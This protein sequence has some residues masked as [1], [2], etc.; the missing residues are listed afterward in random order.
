MKI[1]FDDVVKREM[2]NEISIN[3]RNGLPNAS[4]IS[5]FVYSEVLGAMG[6]MINGEGEN[7]VFGTG[8]SN[9]NFQSYLDY[10]GKVYS[11]VNAKEAYRVIRGGII[12]RY[13]IGRSAL[14]VINPEDPF[15]TVDYRIGCP[16]KITE[17]SVYFNVNQYFR[18]MKVTVNKIRR[19]MKR[20]R[21]ESLEIARSFNRTRLVF[22]TNKEMTQ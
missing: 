22:L 17:E 8:Q 21:L 12:H 6:R 20:E 10:A 7:V 3:I 14:I 18:D 11:D 5:L 9:R 1:F 4:I 15:G 19:K 16:I 13:F 2:Y